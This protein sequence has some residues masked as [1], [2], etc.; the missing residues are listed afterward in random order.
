VLPQNYYSVAQPSAVNLNFIHILSKLNITI[1]TS[2]TAPD[3]E[4]NYYN[5]D[6][7]GFE[8]LNIPSK[9][10]FNENTANPGDNKKWIRW[11]L[12]T[13][14]GTTTSIST[15]LTSSNAV[16]V[17]YTNTAAQDP[18]PANG[19]TVYKKYIVESL[20]IPQSIKYERVAL[21]GG[22]HGV[23][24]AKTATPYQSYSEYEAAKHNDNDV[25]RL[26]KDQFDALITGD[27]NKTFKTWE[28]YNDI[29]GEHL[30]DD[31]QE[32][33]TT[34]NNRVTEASEVVE[35]PKVLAYAP[36]TQPC[37]HITYTIDGEVFE[38]YYNL[39]AAFKN[40]TNNETTGTGDQMAEKVETFDFYEGWQNTLNIIINPRAI[41]F[42]A[43][44]APW[45][46][47]TEVSYEIERINQ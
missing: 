19:N 21:D 38:A 39:A 12:S 13:G 5:V 11:T 6:L 30:K 33:Q 43:D 4:H 1:S 47:N 44:V 28:N 26:T 14:E 7:I 9:G 27:A 25:V 20:M 45:A 31:A 15:G 35:T 37:I 2:L 18:V 46:D 36:P 22:T 10:T 16:D 23:V 34:F 32:G 42:T 40:L 41:S 3:N 29:T 17:P 8:V 24:E